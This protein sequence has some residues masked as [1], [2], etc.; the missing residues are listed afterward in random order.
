VIDGRPE[1][2][3]VF[4]DDTPNDVE[5][6]AEVVVNDLVARAC[7]VLPRNVRLPGFRRVRETLDGLADDLELS[8]VASCRILSAKNAP[9]P[10]LA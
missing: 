8:M 5:I 9:R 4:L 3:Q 1:R 10:M 6:H 2:G 7:D